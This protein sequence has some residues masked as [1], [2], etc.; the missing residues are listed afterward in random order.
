M[1]TEDR[2]RTRPVRRIALTAAPD[3]AA[4]GATATS[5]ASTAVDPGTVSAESSVRAAQQTQWLWSDRGVWKSYSAPVSAKLEDGYRT[6]AQKI[7]I[8]SARY[9]DFLSMHQCR[10]DDPRRRRK[11]RRAGPAASSAPTPAASS[12]SVDL[13]KGIV[14]S[15]VT[16]AAPSTVRS[17]STG[18]A[19]ST[20][21]A[22]DNSLASKQNAADDSLQRLRQS[23]HSAGASGDSSGGRATT[24]NT[25]ASVSSSITTASS[26]SV[27]TGS[28]TST[29]ND[30]DMDMMLKARIARFAA[31]AATR[32]KST[33]G[34]SGSATSDT[35]T[36][37]GTAVAKASAS[38]SF[39][40]SRDSTASTVHSC[41]G[42][43]RSMAS[44]A[45]A[46]EPEEEPSTLELP[47]VDQME[48]AVTL[49]SS[50]AMD[51]FHDEDMGSSND[52]A[53]G[54]VKKRKAPMPKSRSKPAAAF[55]SASSPTAVQSS[56]S[57]FFKPSPAKPTRLGNPATDRLDRGLS[58]AHPDEVMSDI[59]SQ[60]W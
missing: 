24:G 25:S 29:D 34:T 14:V 46:K 36:M 35:V 41:G 3:T 50:T 17:I 27:P 22:S 42:N 13:S 8:D 54:S 31:K 4:L 5:S 60:P 45:S 6:K 26:N 53:A 30:D 20:D 15:N 10:H 39:D 37:S 16:V 57:D 19:V 12:H 40:K 28:N 58:V 51:S 7:D 18:A 47:D 44:D 23:S 43:S 33:T 48:P 11:V 32:R 55:D 2:S 9:V 52:A 59:S 56:L 38:S 21:L 1:R 49:S